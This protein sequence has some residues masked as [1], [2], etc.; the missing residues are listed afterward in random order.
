MRFLRLLTVPAVLLLSVAL[1]V[2]AFAHS[3]TISHLAA[4]CNSDNKVCFD[5]DVTTSSFDANGRDVLVDLVDSAGKTL[6]TKTVHLSTDSTHVHACFMADVS[7]TA[8][9]T[10]KLRV[11]SGSDLELEGSTTKVDTKGCVK[12]P[13]SPSPSPSSSSGGGGGGSPTPTPSA[14]TTVALAETG[15]FD[16][17]FPLIGLALLVA[18]GTLFLVSVSRGRSAGNR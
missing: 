18:G 4:S 10:I 3:A 14:N 6:E 12:P 2:P 5:F 16:F 8:S 13:S 11:P 17:R 9:V 1:A 7:S 15:G